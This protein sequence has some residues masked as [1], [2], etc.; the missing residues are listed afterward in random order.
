[1]STDRQSRIAPGHVLVV[2]NNPL[3]LRMIEEGFNVVAVLTT[4]SIVTDG[5]KAMDFLYLRNEYVEAQRPD[6]ILLDLDVSTKGG[7]DVLIK[8]KSDD[9]LC[10]IP[11]IVLS[12][13]KRSIDIRNAYNNGANCYLTKPSEF[14]DFVELVH[15]IG[16]FW[17]THAALPL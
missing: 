6:L 8:I 2:E 17:F 10:T 7:R 12:M 1:M 14:D 4:L 3:N 5:V 15:A 16:D 13:S 9:A 11:V